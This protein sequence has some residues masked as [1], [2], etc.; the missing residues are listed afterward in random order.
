MH[1]IL[2]QCWWRMLLSN[3]RLHHLQ[4]RAIIQR[5]R[6]ASHA[7]FVPLIRQG[8]HGYPS[9]EDQTLYSPPS[10]PRIGAPSTPG[11]AA[12][13]RPAPGPQADPH[14]CACRLCR[15]L[16]SDAREQNHGH[17]T[18]NAQ[19]PYI[20]LPGSPGSHWTEVITSLPAFGRMLSLRCKRSPP[21][22]A[23]QLWRCCC[24]LRLRPAHRPSR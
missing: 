17:K 15:I 3:L 11:R 24:L 13:R 9:L 18:R 2:R 7:A 19:G 1:R 10:A 20:L 23:R 16:N 21:I 6:S 22:L 5:V 4:I 8:Q 14:L 12:E